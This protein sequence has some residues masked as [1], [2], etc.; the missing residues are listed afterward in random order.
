M[1]TALIFLTSLLLSF[2]AFC[3]EKGIQFEQNKSFKEILAMAKAQNKLIFLDC[4]TKYCGACKL[5]EKE[6]FPQEKVGE[7]YNKTFVNIKMDMEVGEGI[8]LAEKYT[9]TSF[10]TLLYLDYTGEII[11]QRIG[12]GNVDTFLNDGKKAL[13]SQNNFKAIKAKI[14]G[15]D[16]SYDIV[17]QYL[18]YEGIHKNRIEVLENYFK[19]IPKEKIV[20]EESWDLLRFSSRLESD[21]F[22]QIIHDNYQGFCDKI[23]KKKVDDFIENS[24]VFIYSDENGNPIDINLPL[25]EVDYD[26]IKLLPSVALKGCTV[27]EVKVNQNR[28][29]KTIASVSYDSNVL[30]IAKDFKTRVND[31]IVVEIK[32]VVNE[33]GEDVKLVMKYAGLAIK[34]GNEE[35]E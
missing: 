20:T 13:D 11:H 14:D 10:P 19:N 30:T 33:K 35:E 6:V 32:K 34:E 16:Y 3:Q 23:G 27:K 7:Y 29:G 8:G 22:Q 1:K 9:I 25:Y 5:L 12:A 4:Y 26:I 24:R 21:K 15:E 2:S 28:N 17:K 18:S 31:S